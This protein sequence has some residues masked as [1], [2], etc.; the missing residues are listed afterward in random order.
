MRGGVN[1]YDEEE[2]E[3]ESDEVDEEENWEDYEE[4]EGAVAAPR[5]DN[6][7]LIY[8]YFPHTHWL[9]L[10]VFSD[11]SLKLLLAIRR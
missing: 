4:E 8:R 11:A 6:V 10:I 9:I 7:R 1:S 3:D 5:D 2:E